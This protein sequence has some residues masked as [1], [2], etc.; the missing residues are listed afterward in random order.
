MQ[1]AIDLTSKVPIYVQIIDQVKH[2]IATGE[3]RP[4]DQLPGENLGYIWTGLSIFGGILGTVWGFRVGRR[5][6]SLAMAT[7]AKRVGLFWLF[8]IFYAIATIAVTWAHTCG[9][10]KKPDTS[11]S[12]RPSSNASRALSSLPHP[13]DVQSST[14]TWR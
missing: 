7:T 9:N 10:S 2:M 1:V 4:D 5:F 6:H 13:K 8:L 11:P 12:T 3:L 14:N